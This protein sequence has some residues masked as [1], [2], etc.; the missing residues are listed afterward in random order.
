MRNKQVMDERLYRKE[1][2]RG[3]KSFKDAHKETRVRVACY[4]AIGND[5]CL[6]KA[7]NNECDKE[8]CSLNTEAETIVRAGGKE[9][10]VEKGYIKLEVERYENW[11]EIWRK[12]KNIVKEGPKELRIKSFNE[13]KMESEIVS[14]QTGRLRMARTQY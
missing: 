3:L 14:G 4:L 10:K 6:R 12:L 9:V 2:R 8:Q 7:L 1:G 5:E 13:K 11:K